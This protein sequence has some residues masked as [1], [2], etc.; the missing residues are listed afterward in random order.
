MIEYWLKKR[1]S[2]LERG[3]RELL[4]TEDGSDPGNLVQKLY[5]HGM[6]SGLFKG[7]YQDSRIGK[8]S[9]YIAGTRLPSYIPSRNFALALM[10]L[11]LPGTASQPSG[12]TNATPPPPP[13]VKLTA[14]PGRPPAPTAETNPLNDLRQAISTADVLQ[15][16]ERVKK[17][18]ISLV[19]AAGSDVSKARENI[20]TWF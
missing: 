9:R 16:N 15:G 13:D 6:V 4:T 20:E 11:V 5:N 3:V 19:D 18:L 17:A 2:D 14:T 1:S 7:T 12:A 8:L 10:D